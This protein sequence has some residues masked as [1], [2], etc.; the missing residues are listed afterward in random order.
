V[1][2]EP[3]EEEAALYVLALLP[4]A[5]ARRFEAALT[6]DPELADL[7]ARLETAAAALA[8][9]APPREPPP[10]L[11]ERVM[12][13]VRPP[14]ARAPAQRR[15]V[16]LA[17]QWIPWAIAACLAVYVGRLY[18][19]QYRL[20]ILADDFRLRDQSQ[21][22]ALNA[23]Q[24]RLITLQKHYDA[25]LLH[26]S[27]AAS[28]KAAWQAQ[29]AQ[30]KERDTLSQIKIATLASML[31]NA[32]QAMAMVA[33]DGASQRGL[34]RT[35]NMPAAGADRDYQLWIIDPDYKQPVSAGVFDPA[36]GSRFQPLHPIQKAAK[37][38]VSLEK[39]GGVP[40]PQGPIVLLEDS[41]AT[42][43][44]H[45]VGPTRPTSQT[46]PTRPTSQTSPTRP[47][48]QAG[49]ARPINQTGPVKTPAPTR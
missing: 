42:G 6:A 49:P 28:D 10:A 15:I 41:A 22:V 34:L 30:L 27:A 1:I 45:P 37:F 39:K 44:A 21:Q 32:P 31:K 38:A 4:P 12:G 40:A 36:A 26:L 8:H 33:W 2:D 14:I 11:R 3:T 35:V 46:S 17:A 29:L 5:E 18:F 19:M 9:E 23:V 43:P 48:T 7:V 13:Q 24:A 16:H 47:A 25:A 20:S